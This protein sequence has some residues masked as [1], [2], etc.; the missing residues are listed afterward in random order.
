[1]P[2]PITWTQIRDAV[3]SDKVLTMLADQISEGFPPDKKL[4]R[5]ELRE[6]YRHKDCL[7]QVD[8]VPLYKDRVVVPHSLRP[9]VL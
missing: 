8:G 3:E 7:T 2:L 9:A 5:H 6:F 4:L 1:M